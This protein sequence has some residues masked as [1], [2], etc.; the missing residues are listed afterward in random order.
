MKITR[1][2]FLGWTA[3]TIIFGAGALAATPPYSF[4]DF[5]AGSG[6]KVGQFPPNRSAAKL[7]QGSASIVSMPEEDSQQALQLGPQ[8]PT[9]RCSSMLPQ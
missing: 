4:I 2:A 3:F 9:R 7:V 8:I 6:W 5:E 1:T